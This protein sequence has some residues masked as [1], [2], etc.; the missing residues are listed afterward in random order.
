MIFFDLIESLLRGLSGAI[1]RYLRYQYYKRRL[2]S[3]GKGV[4][5]DCGV[6]ISNPRN[7]ELGSNVWL[8]KHTVLL[9]GEIDLKDKSYKVVK[10]TFFT[11][12]SG[13]IKVGDYSH[14]G[15]GTII[16]GHG[17]VSI[18]RYF[19]SS[20]GCKIYSLSNDPENCATGT[21]VNAGYIIHPVSIADNVWLGLQTIVLGHHV[22]E[23]AFIKPN[24]VIYKDIPPGIIFEGYNM[25]S[26]NRFRGNE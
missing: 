9:A 2:K 18:G 19:T 7:V 17:G 6:Y 11:G 21:M 12:K 13:V 14:V 26:R 10:N 5:I 15:I 25:E 24:S 8:D 22:G 16:Q 3:C 1:G 20:A 4:V 23:N